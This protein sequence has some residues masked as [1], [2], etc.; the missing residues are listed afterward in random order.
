M[1]PCRPKLYVRLSFGSTCPLWVKA[2]R[3]LRLWGAAHATAFVSMFFYATINYV[4]ATFAVFVLVVKLLFY[5][6]FFATNLLLSLT[7]TCN[8]RVKKQQLAVHLLFLSLCWSLM[9][10]MEI[11][12]DHYRHYWVQL[13]IV[14]PVQLAFVALQT[15]LCA[16]VNLMIR[17]AVSGG[18]SS[19]FG[20]PVKLRICWPTWNADRQL[21]LQLH[22]RYNWPLASRTAKRAKEAG[23]ATNWLYVCVLCV[24]VFVC[25]GETA[26]NAHV[27]P[28]FQLLRSY[29]T[30]H[31][32]AIICHQ[33]SLLRAT[34]SCCRR[35]HY[36]WQFVAVAFCLLQSTWHLFAHWAPFNWIALNRIWRIR[37]NFNGDGDHQ[38]PFSVASFNNWHRIELVARRWSPEP[39]IIIIIIMI[40]W[41]W[42]LKQAKQI[43]IMIA[44]D[45]QIDSALQFVYCDI[46]CKSKSKSKCK[47]KCKCHCPAGSN[48]IS[49]LC[50]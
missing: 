26:I 46:R 31:V 35:V 24:C 4:G 30:I 17:S 8:C 13:F 15:P 45:A 32:S 14:L 18:Q 16:T 43:E 34:C 39:S 3:P 49:F 29:L 1:H 36:H 33:L 5:F 38:S 40:I 27:E 7:M 23:V 6:L 12:F 42:A 47:C 10:A 9:N 44:D 28:P 2:S 50:F 19:R 20:R 48:H 41:K 11:N 37:S 25:G 22:W 21:Q